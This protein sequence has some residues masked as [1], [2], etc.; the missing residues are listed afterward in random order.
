MSPNILRSFIT[1]QILTII[2]ILLASTFSH[3][4]DKSI[5]DGDYSYIAKLF[6]LS[7]GMISILGNTV[8]VD[9]IPDMDVRNI[10]IGASLGLV[11]AYIKDKVSMPYLV[12]EMKNPKLIY[13]ISIVL[14]ILVYTQLITGYID[15]NLC[16]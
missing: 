2:E 13:H 10:V 16:P 7:F 5:M 1:V 4:N 6:I 11:S 15:N 8:L 3:K 9:I 14:Y 12:Y